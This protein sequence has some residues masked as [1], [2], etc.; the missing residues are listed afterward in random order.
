MNQ[1]HDV[2]IDTALVKALIARQFPIW[3]KLPVRPVAVGGH[4]NRTFHLGDTMSV[5]LPSAIRYAAHVPIEY[6]W[7]PKLA[8]LLPLPISEP[9][10]LGTPSELYP[11]HWTV[12]RWLEG[13]R[14]DRAPIAS[15]LHFAEELA[16]FLHSFHLLDTRAAPQP[17]AHN[18][19]RGGNLKVYD[20]EVQEC[21]SVLADELNTQQVA[22]VWE[23]AL[24][25]THEAKPTWVH[26][27]VAAGN[28]LVQRGKLAAVIDFG[29]LAAGDPACDLTMA[30]TF[31]SGPSRARFQ[32]VLKV[33][34]KTWQRARG[35]GLWKAM[36]GL[37]AHRGKNEE[38]ATQ[39]RNV[40][41]AIVLEHA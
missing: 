15:K 27:D 20:S 17:G 21:L 29:Q 3:A 35:W 13:E 5:R 11:W 14:A 6:E 9:L 31:F 12:N 34:E 32:E 24:D 36:L 7:L 2:T 1:V 26:G 10:A 37:C 23:R 28:L 38:R 25:S 41:S 16:A 18:F 22:S 19:Y 39:A 40:I 4:D 8:P 30:W 33:N